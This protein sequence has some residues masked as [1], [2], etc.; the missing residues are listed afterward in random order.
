MVMIESQPLAAGNTS[1][2]PGLF[3][4]YTV[5]FTTMLSPSQSVG[6][7]VALLFW[8]K[9][10]LMMMIE[11]QPLAAGSISVPLGLASS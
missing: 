9:V 5:P 3:S 10:K 1:I 7:T 4:S 11:S 6:A 2:P 8:L